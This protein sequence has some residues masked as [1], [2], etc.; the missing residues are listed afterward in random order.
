MLAA[1]QRTAPRMN[2]QDVANTLWAVCQA[3]VQASQRVP[4]CLAVCYAAHHGVHDA[5]GSCKQLVG[6]SQAQTHGVSG[7]AAARAVA[8]GPARGAAYERARAASNTLLALATA[9]IQP[10]L[11]SLSSASAASSCRKQSEQGERAGSLATAFGLWQR[12]NLILSDELSEHLQEA[13]LQRAPHMNAQE[14]CNTLWALAYYQTCHSQPAA[15]A[16]V[17]ALLERAS[18]LEDGILSNVSCLPSG[19]LTWCDVWPFVD[20][21]VSA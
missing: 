15:V 4:C 11:R 17:H 12:C 16:L 3:R 9:G 7:H 19:E 13:A 8:G 5:A 14:V 18:N 21:Q 1:V 20:T 2:P 10:H 6:H